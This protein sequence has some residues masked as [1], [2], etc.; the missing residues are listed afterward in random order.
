MYLRFP[1]LPLS[2]DASSFQ[3]GIAPFLSGEDAYG[4]LPV[5]G[6]PKINYLPEVPVLGYR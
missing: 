4:H 6:V 5:R 1:S 2:Q 3:C